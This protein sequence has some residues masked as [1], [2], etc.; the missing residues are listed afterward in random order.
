MDSSV[1]PTHGDQE[2]TAWNGHFGCSCYHPLFL[3]NQFGMLE[4]CALRPGNVHSADGWKAVLEPVMWRYADRDMLKFFRADAAVA[5][6]DL[7]KSLGVAGYFYAIR[8]PANAVLQEQIKHRL[9]RPVGRSRKHVR[10]FYGGLVLDQPSAQADQDRRPR[11]APR[12]RHHLP[13][14]RGRRVGADGPRRCCDGGIRTAASRGLRSRS[15]FV[16]P[17]PERFHPVC[18]RCA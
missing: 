18:R 11:R 7:Y 5:L 9:K 17:S 16:A 4:R 12:P 15:L 10:R 3:F 14:C 2:G 8:L 1:S 6:P 13:A